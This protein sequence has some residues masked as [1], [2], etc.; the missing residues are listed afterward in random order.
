MS[1]WWEALSGVQRFFYYI[2]IPSTVIL[3]MQFILSLF[4]AH[5]DGNVDA[6]GGHIGDLSGHDHDVPTDSADFRFVTFRGIIAFLT[7]FG[8]VGAVLSRF[9]LNVALSVV[10]ATFS[11]LIAMT[12]VAFLFYAI[13][14]LQASG[15]V[16]FKNALGADAEVYIPIP[17]KNSGFGKV[18]V[19]VQGR[20]IEADAITFMETP[21]KTGEIV[22]VV[23]L[24]NG[25]TLVVEKE[26]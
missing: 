24:F 13:S 12:A 15:N 10:I 26:E 8:W 11:G 2:A 17:P 22:R 7:I 5:S 19:L 4:G 1:E 25:T 18:Q 3:V 21:F 23:D 20:L 9:N 6:G 14:H 16:Q